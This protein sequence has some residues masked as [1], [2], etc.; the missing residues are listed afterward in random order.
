MVDLCNLHLDCWKLMASC[1]IALVRL[2]DLGTLVG[3]VY[4]VTMDVV[5]QNFSILVGIARWLVGMPD[6]CAWGCLVRVHTRSETLLCS[7]D[8]FTICA[9]VVFR[10]PG[11]E[12]G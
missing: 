2:R 1:G 4:F 6:E 8:V 7:Y 11:L 12:A 9:P 5:Q 10:A 3:L